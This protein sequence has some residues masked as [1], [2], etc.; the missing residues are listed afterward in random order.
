MDLATVWIEGRHPRGP[1]WNPLCEFVAG[2][3]GPFIVTGSLG[4]IFWIGV[5]EELKP[6]KFSIKISEEDRGGADVDQKH[7]EI[8]G[9]LVRTVFWERTADYDAQGYR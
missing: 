4:S 1:A 2:S 7:P 8:S 5:W 6:C 3:V 9:E